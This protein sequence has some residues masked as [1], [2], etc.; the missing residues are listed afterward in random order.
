MNH[1]IKKRLPLV[2]MFLVLVAG[3]SIL[4]YPMVSDW[5]SVYTAKVEIADY[6]AA[7]EQEDTSQLDAM[8]KQAQE[9]NEALSG[10][11]GTSVASYD[12]LLAVT[13]AIGYLEIPKIGVYMPIYH[14]IDT[15]VL[16]KGIGHMPDTSLP[17][18]GKSTHCVLSG[19]TGLPAAKILTDLD[20][21]EEGDLFYLH[22]L[23][24]TL[25]YKVDQI[26]VVS[27]EDTDDIRITEGK[28]YVTLLTCTP[29]GI[30]S[31]RL[32]VRGERT[33]YVPEAVAVEPP[34]VGTTEEMIPASTIM[35]AGAAG[36]AV[37][38]AVIILLILFLPGKA[39]KGREE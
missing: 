14:G 27:P 12:D 1:N 39:Q 5:L 22:V 20:Q 8:W 31:H 36:A 21:M 23:G 3:I 9:Y 4:G 6:T 35:M 13:D 29:Y 37:L 33:D 15:E 7:V 18:G 26:K 38:V 25:A 10:S 24:K 16:E 30:N 32:L 17:V 11:S 2:F 34:S 19:H 28:D